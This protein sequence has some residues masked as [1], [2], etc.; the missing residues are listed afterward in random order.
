MQKRA[1]QNER[2]MGAKV[3]KNVNWATTVSSQFLHYPIPF[4]LVFQL[5]FTADMS[6]EI[7]WVLCT[8]IALSKKSRTHMLN[9]FD[10]KNR[11]AHYS[12]QKFILTCCSPTMRSHCL[13]LSHPPPPS[14]VYGFSFHL[15][16]RTLAPYLFVFY[17]VTCSRNLNLLSSYNNKRIVT[18]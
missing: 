12:V 18:I 4:S 8:A 15:F 16:T 17:F 7:N 2:R 5:W 10:S 6:G 13:F 11:F 14:H 3:R 9:T 1:R